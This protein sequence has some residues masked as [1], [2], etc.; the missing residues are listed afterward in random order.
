MT[1]GAG[2]KSEGLTVS[3]LRS[4]EVLVLASLAEELVDPPRVLAAVLSDILHA[5]RLSPALPAL[6]PRVPEQLPGESL[7]GCGHNTYMLSAP[8][9]LRHC[10]TP[11]AGRGG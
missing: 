7:R 11:H 1:L 2:L 10:A 5:Q 4:S 3:D 6:L 9:A 8:S